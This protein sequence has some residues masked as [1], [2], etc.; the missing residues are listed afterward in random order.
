M[1]QET[2]IRYLQAELDR[3]NN[4]A[5]KFD[6]AIEQ[7]RREKQVNRDLKQENKLLTNTLA[8][9]EK[10]MNQLTAERDKLRTEN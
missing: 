2:K 4:D 3:K 6:R 8:I 7:I 10:T 9:V 5:K 1:E